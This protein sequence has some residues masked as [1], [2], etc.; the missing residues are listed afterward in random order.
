MWLLWVVA[1]GGGIPM[2]HFP[3][4]ALPGEGAKAPFLLLA[5]LESLPALESDHHHETRL[6]ACFL[7][8]GAR[9]GRR[10]S[11]SRLDMPCS[12]RPPED[13]GPRRTLTGER[14]ILSML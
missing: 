4:E 10:L 13:T 11:T 2:R 5:F 7:R 3:L 14:S 6:A 1:D 12:A 8:P 9:R